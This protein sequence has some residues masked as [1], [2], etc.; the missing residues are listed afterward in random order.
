MGHM[1]GGKE[2][3]NDKEGEVSDKDQPPGPMPQRNESALPPETPTDSIPPEIRSILERS[4]GKI[5]AEVLMSLSMYRGPWPPPNIL[6]E[7]EERFP[8]WG[9]RLLE[10]TAEQVSHRQS[11]ER[12][13]VDRAESRMDRG[14]YFGFS[15]A[16]LSVLTAALVLVFGASGWPST[17]GAAVLAIVGVGGPAVARVLATRFNWSNSERDAPSETREPSSQTAPKPPE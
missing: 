8:G 7:Y 3:A 14:Q 13:Q 15:I 17:V 10:L 6:S 1:T 4:G 2:P 12:K 9:K 11:L 5:T 16:A